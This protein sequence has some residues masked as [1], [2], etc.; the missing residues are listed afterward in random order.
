MKIRIKSFYFFITF[1]ILT[2]SNCAAY[3]GTFTQS[4]LEYFG[5]AF[6]LGGIL[7]SYYSSGP[8]HR[9]RNTTL[10]VALL[11]VLM[12]P[13][14][15][16]QHLPF[17]KKATL[18]FTIIAIILVSTMSENFLPS[19]CTFRLMAYACLLG[20]FTSIIICIE[21]GVPLL[22]RASEATFGYSLYFNG[23]IRDKNV[24]TM[25]IVII[26]SLYIN[27]IETK[28]LKPL[29]VFTFIISIIVIVAANSRGAWIEFAIF[30]LML[31]YKHIEKITKSQRCFIVITALFVIIPIGFLFYN[32]IILKSGTFLYRHRGLINYLTTFRHDSYHMI[33]GN[34]EMAYGSGPDYA[35]NIRS[36][37]GW[38]GTIENSWLNILI[39][40]GVLGVI[41]YIIIFSRAIITALKCRNMKYKTIYLS[42]TIMLFVSSFVAIYIQTVHGLF[43][44]YCYLIMAYFSGIIRKN[45]YF[46]RCNG[47]NVNFS[48]EYITNTL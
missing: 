45:N 5:Y 20:I 46:I 19:F 9:K 24:A 32:N 34:A 21:H 39:K 8:S 6:L 29:D 16:L 43:G 10:W 38:D 36:I 23:G 13:G 3:L 44:I 28:H 48:L 1:F 4:L 25:M 47:R 40:S 31:N 12:V 42:V 22:R 15:L 2:L 37:T 11:F 26:I 27:Y 33:F 7:I 17:F 14:L 41:A 18:L 30:I 35:T